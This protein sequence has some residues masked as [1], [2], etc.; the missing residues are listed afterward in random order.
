MHRAGQA[1]P[2]GP[3]H[4]NTLGIYDLVSNLTALILSLPHPEDPTKFLF[5]KYFQDTGSEIVSPLGD[6]NQPR[7][8]INENAGTSTAILPDELEVKS[9][10]LPSDFVQL[11]SSLSGTE[12]KED[13]ITIRQIF[14][15]QAFVLMRLIAKSMLSIKKYLTTRTGE[16][17]KTLYPN[18]I[19]QGVFPLQL[20]PS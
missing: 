20:T 17:I 14:G 9:S 6:H 5:S 8:K 13:F 16:S 2:R 18:F 1:R 4:S 15:F 19:S 12:K 7:M 10:E 3:V 11:V